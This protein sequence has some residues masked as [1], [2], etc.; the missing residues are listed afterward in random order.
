MAESEAI[1]VALVGCEAV[2]RRYY[3][4]LMEV[5]LYERT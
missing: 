2:C 3:A 4:P 1:S 5:R